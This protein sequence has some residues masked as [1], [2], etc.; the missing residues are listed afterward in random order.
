MVS[1]LYL[2]RS[3]RATGFIKIT[4]AAASTDRK[5]AVVPLKISVE[6]LPQVSA[7]DVAEVLLAITENNLSTSVP[8][9]ENAGRTLRHAGVVRQLSVIGN[10]QPGLTSIIRIESMLA[11]GWKRRNLRAV[12]F[13]QERDNR[14]VLGAASLKLA[15]Q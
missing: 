13:V 2:N 9:G 11:D 7:G 12:V 4:R 3:Y 1:I 15:E 8:R 6:N 14:R 5:A 10:A